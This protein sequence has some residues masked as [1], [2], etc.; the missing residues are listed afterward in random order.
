VTPSTTAT[1]VIAAAQ[2][3]GPGVRTISQALAHAV[4]TPHRG[5][6]FAVFARSG[7]GGEYVLAQ[8][9]GYSQEQLDHARP[10]LVFRLGEERG[11]VGLAA[12]EGRSIY[13][14][15]CLR[16][17]R[18]IGRAQTVPIR[19]AY[20]VPVLARTPPHEVLCVLSDS[21]NG[22][23]PV[24]RSLA[25]L[26][27]DFAAQAAAIEAQLTHALERL[28]VSVERLAIGFDEIRILA[29]RTHGDFPKDLAAGLKTL[30]SREWDVVR[31]LASGQRV[32]TIARGLFVS[33]HTIRN[34]LK[35]IFRKVGVS[36][37]AELRERLGAR[38]VGTD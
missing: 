28:E 7:P 8:A 5:L 22:I 11:L 24:V 10:K 20:L 17:P 18:W 13:L 29:G 15:D 21:R 33:P 19:S 32:G 2:A 16:D 3:A 6:N 14:A 34:H 1:G 35:S 38:V 37:Q 30:S 31:R 12:A 4:S 36:S 9:Q 23:S 25:D 27:A 26:I